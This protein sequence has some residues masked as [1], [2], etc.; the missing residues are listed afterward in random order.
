MICTSLV[1]VFVFLS[2]CVSLYFSVTSFSSPILTPYY[3]LM[4][5]P[6][7]HDKVFT[8]LALLETP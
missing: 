3:P 8:I 7:Y 1:F 2:L 4:L 6:V 5:C